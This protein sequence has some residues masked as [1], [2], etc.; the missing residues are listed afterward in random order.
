[1]QTY[2]SQFAFVWRMSAY[3]ASRGALHHLSAPT[4]LSLGCHELRA[5]APAADLD[6]ALYSLRKSPPKLI[7]V[8]L[9]E[10]AQFFNEYFPWLG[11]RAAKAITR[12]V[13]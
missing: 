9:H 8:R 1:M 13:L 11:S 12:Q 3:Q 4:S 5:I 6:L 2:S 7:P 10:T